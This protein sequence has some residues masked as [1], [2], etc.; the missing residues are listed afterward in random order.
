MTLPRR[1]VTFAWRV[2]NWLARQARQRRVSTLMTPSPALVSVGDLGAVLARQPGSV[3]A[4]DVFDTLVRRTVNPEKVKLL[5]LDR[6]RHRLALSG[7]NTAGLYR[8]RHRIETEL[9]RANADAHGEL[10][11]RFA[12]MAR[13]LHQEL[14]AARIVPAP[15]DPDDFVEALFDCELGMERSVLHPIPEVVAALAAAQAGGRTV[16]LIS[17]FYLPASRLRTLLAGV[18]V[19][20]APDRVFVSCDR[21]ASKRS[22]RIFPIVAEQLGVAPADMVMVGDN[23]HS[24]GA[25]AKAGGLTSVLLNAQANHAFYTSA[26]ADP[27]LW[28]NAEQAFRSVMEASGAA[29]TRAM[30]MVAPALLLFIERLYRQAR[31]NG[32]HHLFFLAREGQLLQDLFEAHQTALGLSGEARIATHYLTVSRRA[33]FLCSL[34]PLDEEDFAGLFANYQRISLADFLNSLRFTA[35]E[36]IGFAKELDLDAARCEE[37]F[38]TSETFARLRAL[39]RFRNAYEDRRSEQRGNFL[40]YLDQFGVDLTAHPL[41]LVDVGWKGTIQDFIRAI[42]PPAVDIQGFYLGLLSAGQSVANK[43]GLLFSNVGGV[44]SG[45]FVY[46]ENRSLFEI[47]LYADHG[48]AHGYV[49]GPD[50]RVNVTLDDNADEAAFVRTYVKPI[51]D[52]L[53]NTVKALD[54]ARGLY[55]ISDNQWEEFAK[56]AHGNL[57][58]S[59]WNG[60]LGWLVNA[61]HRENFG[62]FGISTFGSERSPSLQERLSFLVRLLRGPRHVLG[63]SFWPSFTLYQYGGRALIACYAGYRRWQERRLAL[64]LGALQ[65]EAPSNE[66]S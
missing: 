62:V 17:D 34:R 6:L 8:L 54:Q 13:A 30:R 59:P 48:S 39:P 42:V 41:V 21:M 38:P 50:G 52:D 56:D 26:A 7:I 31:R 10:E 66:H 65:S 16:I 57:V 35:D 40:A 3:I 36:V 51:A 2:K 47:L 49:R 29:E 4:F 43:T 9:C 14:L 45:F 60:T 28:P 12:D 63:G 44:T 20:V 24:D 11:F 5:A 37:D 46:G 18:G 15:S 64:S 23:P 19:S 27:S 32:Y 1:Q 55:C 25:M 58:F 53:I 33:C 61:R 22:G